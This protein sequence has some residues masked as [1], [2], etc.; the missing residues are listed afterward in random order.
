MGIDVSI[1]GG[2]HGHSLDVLPNNALRVSLTPTPASDVRKADVQ[3]RRAFTA[4]LADSSGSTDLTVD[5]SSTAVEFTVGSS[6]TEIR[7]IN[8]VRLIFHDSQM[9]ITNAESRRFGS[10]AASPGLPNGLLLQSCQDGD[11]ADLFLSGV[12]SIGDFQRY[13]ALPSRG[14]VSDVGAIT[15]SIDFLMIAVCLPVP[16]GLYPG[17][18]DDLT[19]TV[20]D[21]LSNL[22]LFEV[23]ASGWREIL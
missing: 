13:A 23:Q 15:S 10:A 14:I 19:V 17:T 8:E 18:I 6:P 7:W 22:T 11:C 21:D 5:G 20:Q 9:N 12:Q 16:L 2:P 1:R 4:L 3:N